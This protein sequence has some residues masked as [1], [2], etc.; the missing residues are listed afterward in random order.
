MAD[1]SSAFRI[2]QVDWAQRQ[3]QYQRASLRIPFGLAVAGLLLYALVSDNLLVS[4]GIPYNAPSGSFLFKL[5]PGT[6]L[7]T[8][9]FLLL[10][11]RD[12]PRRILPRLWATAAAA[13]LLAGTILGVMVYTVVRFGPSGNAFFIDTLLAPALLAMVLLMGPLEWRRWVFRI[14]VGLLALNA[15]IGIGEAL[16]EERL[17]PYLAGDQPIIEEFFRATALGGHP[18]T[19]ALRTATVLIA[20]L[21]LPYRWLL[22]LIP[23]FVIALLAFGGRTALATGVLLLLGWS[24]YYFFRGIVVRTFDVRLVFGLLLMALLLVGAIIGLTVSLDLGE[25]IFANLSWDSSAQSRLLIFRVFDYFD[26]DD[27]LWG[28]GPAGISEVLERLKGLTTL[29]DFEN[30]W[31]LLLM[32]VGLAWFV[33]VS[34]ALLGFIASLVWRAPPALKLS[35]VSF[36]LIASSNNSLASKSQTLAILAALLIGGAA[37]AVMAAQKLSLARY[38]D[39]RRG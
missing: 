6:Y 38:P 2:P 35:A 11:V 8:L 5:H 4:M 14:L 1:A 16:F 21:I 39:S 28:M 29:T 20:C 7:I 10:L 13:L 30:F 27:W 26:L 34:I 37:E 17:T 24:V 33:L 15:L 12:H 9:S 22:I 25:R 3:R 18:L 23:L 19:N 31:I 36:L 32:Q